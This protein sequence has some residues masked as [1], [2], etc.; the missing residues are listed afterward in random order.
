MTKYLHGCDGDHAGDAKGGVG[1]GGVRECPG[2]RVVESES[3]RVGEC[4]SG[5]IFLLPSD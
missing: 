1:D 3:V 4:H 5:S 2:V